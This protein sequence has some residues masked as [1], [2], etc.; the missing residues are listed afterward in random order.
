MQVI[1]YAEVIPAG[2]LP[3]V[4]APLLRSSPLLRHS[5]VVR[6]LTLDATSSTWRKD[7][8]EDRKNSDK[9]YRGVTGQQQ[10]LEAM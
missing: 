5:G 3:R 6:A 9:R 10:S 1:G 7:N 4:T 8:H 2:Y